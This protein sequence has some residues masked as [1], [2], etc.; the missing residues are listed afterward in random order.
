MSFKIARLGAGDWLILAGS[1]GLLVDL[2]V[3]DWFSYPDGFYAYPRG[4]HPGP[5]AAGMLSAQNG[6]Q[7]LAWLGPLAAVIGAI[8]ILTFG[9]QALRRSPAVPVVLTTLLTPVALL[10][11]LG[12]AART[13]IAAPGTELRR[14]GG[15]VAL[16]ADAGAYVGLG[17][18]VVIVIGL[19]TSLRREGIAPADAPA[20]IETIKLGSGH[21]EWRP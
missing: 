12:I 16:A 18:S 15:G 4:G 2:F 19:Y 3:G 17:L 21:L 5:I 13:L 10:L 1:V 9:A 8:G 20:E 7:A 11:A 14:V 6:W